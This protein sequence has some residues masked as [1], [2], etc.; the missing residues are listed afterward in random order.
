MWTFK[1]LGLPGPIPVAWGQDKGNSLVLSEGIKYVMRLSDWAESYFSHGQV[2][3]PDIVKTKHKIIEEVAR[4]VGRMH[5]K[6]LHHQDLYLCHFLYGPGHDGLPLTLI[7]LQRVEQF[8]RLSRKWQIKDLAQ[9]HFSS[10][11][12]IT[13]HDIW[14][15]WR[16]YSSIYQNRIKRISLW[17]S[18]LRKSKRIRRH[19][20]KHGL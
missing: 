2:I 8:R 1:E 18:I 7:D 11:P 16:I 14:R 6:G 17:H 20:L 5:A 13:R 15:F 9:L 12:Y 3:G 10:A 4:I 19:T